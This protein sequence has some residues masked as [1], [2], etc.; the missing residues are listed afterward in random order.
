L[1]QPYINTKTKALTAISLIAFASSLFWPVNLSK[2]IQ[3][4]PTLYDRNGELIHIERN[5]HDC[6]MLKPQIIDQQI[7]ELLLNFEDKWFYY[8]PGVNPLAMARA[9]GQA[10]I[11][12][13]IL[14]GGSTITMQV[15]RLF[16]PG[17]RTLWKKLSEIHTALRLTTQYSKDEVLKMYLT[18][19]PYGGN[20]HGIRAASL[21]YFGREPHLLPLSYKAMLVAI[22]QS[23]S[24]LRPDRFI[25]KAN[26]AKNKVLQRMVKNTVADTTTDIHFNTHHLPPPPSS[27][28]GKFKEK[29]LNFWLK[30]KFYK[31]YFSGDMLQ[32][33]LTETCQIH[34][35]PFIKLAPH[36]FTLKKPVA[37]DKFTQQSITTI[38]S[39][40]VEKL[41]L[42]MNAACIVYNFKTDQVIVYIGSVGGAHRM[43]GND[44]CQAVRSP[45]SLLKPFIYGLAMERGYITPQTLITDKPINLKDYSPENFD[46]GFSGDISIEEALQQSLNTPVIQVLNQVGPGYFFDWLKQKHVSVHFKPYNTK[47]PGLAIGLGGIGMNLSELVQVFGN[48]A[49]GALMSQPTQ[50]WLTQTMAQTPMP[51]QRLKNPGIAYK[52][53]TSYGFRDA[54]S[55]GYDNQY[56]VGI[57]VGRADGT[58]C[59]GYH[60]R[61]VAAPL[62]MQIFNSLGVTP[63]VFANNPSS[64]QHQPL[65]FRSQEKSDFRITMP[66]KA[67]I[68]CIP[69]G[70]AMYLQSNSN[71]TVL[72]YVNGAYVG[73]SKTAQAWT[74]QA[75]GFYHI[76]A[77]DDKNTID[78][79]QIEIR[80]E[81]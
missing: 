26:I 36:A 56:V 3:E 61:Q 62:M 50:D 25:D 24:H 67:T 28:W 72:W 39:A 80:R 74:P 73:E 54:W 29:F 76:T 55:I 4:S 51:D 5:S 77:M 44:M 7:K 71:N 41:P 59:P 79:C 31:K 69:E 48:L 43:D 35:T 68:L 8:H 46:M 75:P 33:A 58:P 2:Y 21:Y 23:P 9:L 20:I 63:I 37:L 45:G 57:W 22:P 64:Q 11:H 40:Y 65:R 70:D 6:W 34:V 66:K 13:K 81:P 14:S 42:P 60:G 12:Q 52:T 18:L 27:G 78:T 38:I 1:L 30:N 47:R 19:A 32:E 10:V 49:K 16:N 15:A 17:P 53:G